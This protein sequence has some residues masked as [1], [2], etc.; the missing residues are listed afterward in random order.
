M[1]VQGSG[2]RVQDAGLRVQALGFT[3]SVLGVLWNLP[4]GVRGTGRSGTSCNQDDE[5]G[6]SLIYWQHSTFASGAR[7]CRVPP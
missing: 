1:G 7:N 2:A 5:C 3:S 6:Y 4:F